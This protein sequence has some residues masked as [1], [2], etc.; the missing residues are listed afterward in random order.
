M[1]ASDLK[2]LQR[3][4][5]LSYMLTSCTL[6]LIVLLTVGVL[7]Y[8]NLI[9]NTKRTIR[10]DL[11][12]YVE[13]LSAEHWIDHTFFGKEE[14][15]N[16]Y[17]I[18]ILDCNK[19]TLFQGSLLDPK[20]R[21]LLW[22]EIEENEITFS[23]ST[24]IN[25]LS[26]FFY[27]FRHESEDGLI[28][29]YICKD[30]KTVRETL[31]LYLLI[32]G[33]GFII[34]CILLYFASLRMAMGSVKPIRENMENQIAFVHAAS[35]ELKSPL[36]VI[37]TN[38]SA[39]TAD[40][41]NRD[42]YHKIIDDE[43]QRMAKLISELL[44]VASG[45][46]GS[47]Y[48]KRIPE[49]P[50]TILIRCYEDM[51][52]LVSSAGMPLSIDLGEQEFGNILV[53]KDRILQVL[54]TLVGNAI[55]YGASEKGILLQLQKEKKQISFIVRDYGKGISP[56]QADHIFDR[57]YRG[58]ED[59]SEKDHFGLGLSIAKQLTTDMGG[60]IYLQHLDEPGAS[61]VVTFREI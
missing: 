27:V 22:S 55:A 33:I 54:Q 41:E 20:E 10:Y 23:Q 28:Q 38:N 53:D 14:V 1:N 46:Q 31:I 13:Q 16:D 60:R 4:I 7:L 37:R 61:F 24:S 59:R 8:Q 58:N 43:C 25:L 45:N 17:V 57:F 48:I 52:P 35:H 36:A 44:F 21:A 50:D 18:Y 30:L 34:G 42:K 19:Q 2:T 51:L 39:C 5:S 6:L 12:R 32:L 9:Q 49:R 11:S 29:C 3:K 47:R 56:R 40:A 26:R 15:E